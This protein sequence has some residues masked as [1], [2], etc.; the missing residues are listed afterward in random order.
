[1]F[2]SHWL[3]AR[4]LSLLKSAGFRDDLDTW[5]VSLAYDLLEHGR[6]CINCQVASVGRCFR[7][8]TYSIHH[9]LGPNHASFLKHPPIYQFCYRGSA[10]HGSHAALRAKANFRN[11]TIFDLCRELQDIPARGILHL[12]PSV[13][14]RHFSCIAR[15]FEIIE[16]L[17]RVHQREL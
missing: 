7:Q 13:G 14:I 10:G 15:M 1:M 12:R 17:R 4:S 5:A 11:S 2:V 6:E 9:I 3:L 8:T 16:E